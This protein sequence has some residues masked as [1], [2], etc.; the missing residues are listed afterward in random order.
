MEEEG[1]D[2]EAIDQ[3][4]TY[5]LLLLLGPKDKP[6]SQLKLLAHIC[7]LVKETT[8]VEKLKKAD[9]PEEICA[10]FKQEERKIE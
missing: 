9:S 6:G 1:M 2:Y 5:V 3:K 10:L 4:P 7:R 8:I